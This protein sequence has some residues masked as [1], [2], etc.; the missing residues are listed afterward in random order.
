MGRICVM[1]SFILFGLS[2]SAAFP[3]LIYRFTSILENLQNQTNCQYDVH[4][5]RPDHFVL[6]ISNDLSK[7]SMQVDLTTA[8]IRSLQGFR[9]G[10]SSETEDFASKPGSLTAKWQN[11]VFQVNPK[12]HSIVGIQAL[13]MTANEDPI[14]TSYSHPVKSSLQCQ[15]V[16]SL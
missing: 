7:N 13:A 2:A 1:V 10:V 12:T 16:Q 3:S 14:S 15:K 9:I 4:V 6:K 11:L 5:V 8:D